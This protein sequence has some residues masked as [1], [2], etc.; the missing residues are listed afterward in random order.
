MIDFVNS[1]Q[2]ELFLSTVKNSGVSEME[3]GFPERELKLKFAPPPVVEELPHVE[4]KA[5]LKRSNI[6]KA[7]HIGIFHI[8]PHF[9]SEVEFDVKKGDQLGMI[10]TAGVSYDIKA[11]ISG[12]GKFLVRDGV[13]ADYGMPLFETFE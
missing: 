12:H 10:Q 11:E 1:D 5:P 8:N 3:L 6:I 13:I 9:K 7:R 4:F 2:L